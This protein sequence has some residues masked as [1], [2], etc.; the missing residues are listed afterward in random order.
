MAGAGGG[1]GGAHDTPGAAYVSTR[2]RHAHAVDTDA[3]AVS[4][5]ATAPPCETD[6]SASEMSGD[7]PAVP[8]ACAHGSVPPPPPLRTVIRSAVALPAGS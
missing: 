2:S 3:P 6:S 7:T 4:G 5:D 1:G 8:S